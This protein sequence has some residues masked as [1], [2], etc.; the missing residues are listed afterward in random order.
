MIRGVEN[1]PNIAVI[2]SCYKND[3][4]NF[5]KES[6]KS[7]L[8]QTYRN[9]HLFIKFDGPV[10]SVVQN[11]ILSI[12]DT[13]VSTIPRDENKGLAYTLNELIDEALKHKDCKYIARMDAD[14]ICSLDRLEK[15]LIFLEKHEDID[16]VGSWCEEIDKNNNFLFLKKMPSNDATLKKN[17]VKRCPFVHP[18]VLMRRCIFENGNRYNIGSYL[19]EDYILWIS[20]AI[21]GHKFGNISEP[22]IKFRIDDNFYRRRLGFK[23]AVAE[24]RGRLYIMQRLNQHTVKNYFW[25][26]SAFLMRLSPRLLNI[27]AYKL[28]R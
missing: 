14:D 4:I 6:I 24:F 27:I 17:L 11:Y 7:L 15:Q 12:D 1:M 22:L 28:F 25:T 20:L 5:V 10:D 18:S 23:K 3:K 8:C 16:I 13:R 2:M 9:F 21:Q 19:S 26:L